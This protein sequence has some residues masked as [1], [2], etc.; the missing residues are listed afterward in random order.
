M[1]KLIAN[2]VIRNEADKYL[3]RVLSR[4]VNQVDEICIT[5][6]CSDDNSIE[7]AKSFGA[8]VFSMDEPTFMRNEG[9]LRQ[10]AWYNLES[11]IDNTKNTWILAIDADEELYA[12]TYSLEDLT[13]Q[14]AFEVIPIEFYHMW[15][16][17]SFRVD[18][19]WRPTK[20]TRLFK[21]YE[22]GK[23]LNRALAC[24]SEP[25]YVMELIRRGKFMQESGLKMKHLS[26]IKNEDKK[27][28]YDRYMAIDGG[29]F[30]SNAHII[31]IMDQ[32]VSLM[33]WKWDNKQEYIN[34]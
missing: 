6:D 24:G 10:Q 7:I 32:Q 17:E 21:Y 4:L 18:K 23:F 25:T 13:E 14:G 3:E 29:A 34:Q 30:H 2:M 1:S 33:P 27:A 16:E 20:S 8:H 31:S 11:I 19:A 28:K 9:L 5:D 12:T 26:Y 22:N 15:N